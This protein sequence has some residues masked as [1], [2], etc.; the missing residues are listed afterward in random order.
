MKKTLLFMICG[1][2]LLGC[3]QSGKDGVLSER[4]LDRP[5]IIMIEVDD[6]TAKYLGFNGGKFAQTPNVDELAKDGVV[7][8]NAV[9]Q[10]TMCTPSRNSIITGLYPH[11][12]GMYHNLDLNQLPTDTWTFPK[13]LQ[14]LGYTTMFLGKNHLIPNL[15]GH[16][17]NSP[18]ELRDLTLKAEMGFDTVYQSMGRAVILNRLRQQAKSNKIGPQEMII[19]VIS[20][21]KM[22]SSKPLEQKIGITYHLTS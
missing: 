13:E 19:M 14:K 12:L 7:F 10:G 15:K 6:L 18:S 16:N 22:D 11:N 4:S 8:L 9:V 17:A 1:L 2:T 21:L 3:I 20:Y 5:N